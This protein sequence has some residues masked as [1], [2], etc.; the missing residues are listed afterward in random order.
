MSTETRASQKICYD[1]SFSNRLLSHTLLSRFSV[2]ATGGI[3]YMDFVVKK[4]SLP[5]LMPMRS[6]M[7]NIIEDLV[8][9]PE[10]TTILQTLIE[11]ARKRD[12]WETL[13]I[14]AAY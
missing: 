13:R 2:R 7:A 11:D 1:A 10:V 3:L 5:G 4:C 14:D 9:R 8:L 12:E 6:R